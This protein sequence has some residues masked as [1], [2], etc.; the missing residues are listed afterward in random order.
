VELESSTFRAVGDL[1][2][3][4]RDPIGL[5]NDDPVQGRRYHSLARS[6]RIDHRAPRPTDVDNRNTRTL[7]TCRIFVVIVRNN[8]DGVGLFDRRSVE[9]RKKHC[10]IT[11]YGRDVGENATPSQRPTN[12]EKLHPWRR[13]DRLVANETRP[14]NDV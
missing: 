5:G 9:P 12:G 11:V 3:T 13:T 6:N 10:R 8:S 7:D 4:R 1:D 2:P 14:P